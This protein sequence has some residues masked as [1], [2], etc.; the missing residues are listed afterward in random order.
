MSFY[1]NM[2]TNKRQDVNLETA[3]IERA[4]T[5]IGHLLALGFGEAGSQII[6]H[7][8]TS[9]GD[10]DPMMQGQRIDAIFGFCDIREFA[11]STEVLQTRIMTFVNKIADIVHSQVNKYGG[12]VNKN[13]GEAFLLV[14]KIKPRRKAGSLH[15]VSDKKTADM[16]LLSF[17]KILAKINR[18]SSILRYREE[19]KSIREDYRVAMGFGLHQ[20]WA[21]EGAIGSYFKIDASYLSPNVNIAARLEAATR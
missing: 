17:I 8:M 10:L 20:G 9:A 3:L 15:Q 1:E 5:R 7:N 12:S 18:S 11:D 13:M 16:A 2:I 6:A 14:W 4:L 21:I 19:L